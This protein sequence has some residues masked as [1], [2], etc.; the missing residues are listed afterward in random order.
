MILG[1]AE[2]Y[3]KGVTHFVSF[4]EW[5]VQHYS[6]T[7]ASQDKEADCSCVEKLLTDCAD[8]LQMFAN[9][10]SK[11]VVREG[12]AVVEAWSSM[13]EVPQA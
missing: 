7:L 1:Q 6:T 11:V 2:H 13:V 4:A 3:S 5:V 12:F 8:V 9:G 10:H